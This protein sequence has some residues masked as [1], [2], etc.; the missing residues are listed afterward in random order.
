MMHVMLVMMLVMLGMVVLLML[1]LVVMMLVMVGYSTER[2][3]TYV[4]GSDA[5]LSHQCRC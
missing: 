3:S 4:L 1:R 5:L 2:A